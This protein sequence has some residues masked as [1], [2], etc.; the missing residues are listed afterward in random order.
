MLKSLHLWFIAVHQSYSV[1]VFH[2]QI[3]MSV[4]RLSGSK[5]TSQQALENLFAQ[6]PDRLNDY[7]GLYPAGGSWGVL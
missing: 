6:P 3:Y 7:C 4:F 5:Q 2:E 1:W